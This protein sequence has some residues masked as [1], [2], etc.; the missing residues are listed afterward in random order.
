MTTTIHRAPPPFADQTHPG[1]PQACDNQHCTAHRAATGLIRETAPRT[2]AEQAAADII[3]DHQ[4]ALWWAHDRDLAVALILA[5]AGLLRDKQYEEQQNRAAVA[6]A[7]HRE[8]RRLADAA[9]I[10]R[11]GELID[12]AAGLLEQGTH[13]ATVAAQLREHAERVRE[14]HDRRIADAA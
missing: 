1:T 7:K 13:P 2:P 5:R 4:W 3:R 10:S 11:L 8:R 9:A 14:R 6:D 12:T